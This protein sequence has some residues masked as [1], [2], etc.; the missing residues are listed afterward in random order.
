M[1]HSLSR[2]GFTL[3]ELLVVI[4][5]IAILIGLLVPAVQQVRESANR[6]QCLNNLKQINLAALHYESVNKKLPPGNGKIFVEIL[7]Y[8]EQQH[9]AELH[10]RNQNQANL[11]R[12]PF[13]ECPSNPNLTAVA[14]ATSSSES[15]Y[16]GTV[17]QPDRPR[18]ASLDWARVDYAGNAG[19]TTNFTVNGVSAMKYR[20]PFPSN[21]EILLR[22][23]VD[24]T[25]N[26]IGFGEIALQNCHATTG[27]CN[28]TWSARPA[29]KWSNYSPT[30][31]GVTRP[32]N[33]NQNFGFSSRH[34]GVVNFGFLDGS[35]RPVRFFGF[36]TGGSNSP[37]E[38][39]T[40]QRMCGKADREPIDG[41]LE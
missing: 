10:A 9:L 26:T 24:G 21:A 8:V 32:G 4:A 28:M 33:W 27:G 37:P 17:E 15:S 2:V 38:Y 34:T 29:V 13:Y 1:N 41:T 16:G 12:V 19:N 11:N 40:F 7:P 20:G 25:S 18:P 22:Q 3:I 39:W 14:N 5:I 23:V 35:I 36:F 6:S 30:P 31:S